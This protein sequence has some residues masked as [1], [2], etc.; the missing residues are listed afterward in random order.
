MSIDRLNDDLDS[1][2][3][4]TADKPR[5]GKKQRK[6]GAIDRDTVRRHAFRLLSA[7]ANYGAP[8]RQRILQYALKR[9]RA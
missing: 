9:N 1:V 3:N 7:I 6:P 2:F 4:G 8:V 5:K